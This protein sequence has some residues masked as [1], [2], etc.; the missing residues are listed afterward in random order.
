MSFTGFDMVVVAVFEWF[1]AMFVRVTRL[2]FHVLICS[3]S[4][5][6]N[7][8]L[9]VELYYDIALGDILG[10]T[11]RERASLQLAALGFSWTACGALC[12]T[13]TIALH[14][15]KLACPLVRWCLCWKR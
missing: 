10:P 11:W 1:L 9:T 7:K 15:K 8:V 5:M 14:L 13:A 12:F 6:R 3:A 2:E 4:R